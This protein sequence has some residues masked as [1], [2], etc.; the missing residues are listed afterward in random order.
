MWMFCKSGMFSAVKH[1]K[2]EGV[3]LVRTRLEGDLERLFKNHGLSDK[4]TATE[5]LD[6]DYRY[7]VEMDAADWVRCVTEEAESIDYGNFKDAVHDG[8]V[9][10]AAY[11]EC[12]CAM[13]NAQRDQV[14]KGVPRHCRPWFM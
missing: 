5:T 13:N 12:W 7:R 3:M 9:R 11:M 8:T 6:A 10:D 14:Y 2:K 1:N 4:Y